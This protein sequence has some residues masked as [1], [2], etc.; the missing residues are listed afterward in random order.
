MNGRSICTLLA[1]VLLIAGNCWSMEESDSLHCVMVSPAEQF[2]ATKLIL[3]VSLAAVG[4]FGI[5]NGWAKSVNGNVRDGMAHL[6]GDCYFHADDYIQYVPAASF[7]GLGFIPGVSHSHNFKERLCAGVT[8]YAVMA[9]VTNVTKVAVNEPRPDSGSRNSFPSGHTATA[10]TGAELMRLEYGV[11]G[12]ISGYTMATGVAFLRL[13]NNRHWFNDVLAGAGIGILSANVGY[14][15]LPLERKLFK[16]RNS[17][18]VMI[19]PYA[20]SQNYGFT[21]LAE[22]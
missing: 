21:F 10:F 8:A 9:L 20:S 19:V 6:R 1:C 13:Y 22:F 2:K 11:W 3:P 17:K 12:G 16:I 4:C 5:S 18:D 14:W 15:L 7:I